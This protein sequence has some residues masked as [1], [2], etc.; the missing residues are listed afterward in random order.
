MKYSNE[1]SDERRVSEPVQVYLRPRERDR[2]ARLTTKL[3]ATK[4]DVLRRGLEALENQLFDPE[5][6]PAL[7]IIGIASTSDAPP[8]DVA[9]SHDEYLAAA[10]IASWPAT[11]RRRARWGG[12]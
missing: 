10:E 12:E 4:S 5:R 6:H 3:D 11:P 2:L 1:R 7:D 8:I 9:R